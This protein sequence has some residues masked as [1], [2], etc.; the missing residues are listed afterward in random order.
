MMRIAV[1]NWTSRKVGGTEAYLDEVVPELS[2]L[3][4]M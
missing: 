3:A 1:A 4:M 2:P